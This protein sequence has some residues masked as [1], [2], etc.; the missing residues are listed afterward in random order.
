MTVA[1]NVPEYPGTGIIPAAPW[2]GLL[3]TKLSAPR[4]RPN[5]V[6]RPRL[7]N[8]ISSADSGLTL[9]CAPA[10][11]GKSTLVTQWLIQAGIPTA[12]VSLD[13]HDDHPLTFFALVVAAIQ[14]I[15]RD[16]AAGTWQMI[17]DPTPPSAQMVVRSLIA[18]ISATTRAFA[19]VLDDYQAIETPDIHAAMA[20]LLQ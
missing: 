8:A 13:A 10:G 14:T 12:W 6:E 19:L 11:Y 18:E 5:L 15:D 7:M 17:N 20:I 2:I 16:L 3:T 4:L 1:R 9:I